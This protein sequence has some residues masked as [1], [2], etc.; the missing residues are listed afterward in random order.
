MLF[1]QVS[2]PISQGITDFQ[3]FHLLQFFRLVSYQ[4]GWLI[5][6]IDTWLIAV[7]F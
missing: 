6:A 7:I 4:E 5:I 3:D 2:L 1:E